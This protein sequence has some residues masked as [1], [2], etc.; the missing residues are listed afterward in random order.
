MTT[1]K[2][3]LMMLVG[4]CVMSALCASTLAAQKTSGLKGN[5]APN[6]KAERCINEPADGMKSLDACRGDVILIKLW[7]VKCPPCLK[8]MP[9]VNALWSKFEGKGLHIFMLERQGHSESEIRTLYTNRGLKMPQ[10]L[11]G[12]FGGYPGVGSIPYAY[13][14]GVDGKVIWEGNSGYVGVIDEEIKKIKYLGLGKQDVHKDL[15]KSAAAFGAGEFGK[16][17][18]EALKARE[19]NSEVAEDADYIIARVDAKAATLRKKAD[20][21]KAARRYHE[22][23]KVLEELS[24]KGFKGMEAATAA[25]EEIKEMKK[26]KDIA[27]ELKA[28]DAL[29][30]TIES[31]EKVKD[32][33]TRK[34]NLLNFVK[35]NEGMAAAEEAEKLAAEI[36]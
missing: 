20:E 11:E 32:A 17:R 25:A 28:W 22:T 6:F 31:N 18:E 30:K 14:I 2:T 10:V 15:E 19:K 3:S 8:S 33:A 21:T 29:A 16:A 23:L 27:K 36:G 1:S 12:E 9:E 5:D 26:D 4:M 35:K 7:G 13:V 24:G 34:T